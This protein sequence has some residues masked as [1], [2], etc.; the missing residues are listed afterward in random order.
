MKTIINYFDTLFLFQ[1]D[2]VRKNNGDN[3]N[4]ILKLGKII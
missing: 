2:K 1:F 4:E 3:K